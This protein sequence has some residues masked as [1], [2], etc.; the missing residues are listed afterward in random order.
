MGLKLDI[1]LAL[2]I[3]EYR[4]RLGGASCE[5]VP[6]NAVLLRPPPNRKKTSGAIAWI[7]TAP[8]RDVQC[9]GVQPPSLSGH[10][11]VADHN[12][13]QVRFLGSIEWVDMKS[14]TRQHN[15]EEAR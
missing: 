9:A 10:D 8:I 15:V 5:D 13:W 7:R 2:E 4:L 11:D 14:R 3:E 6:W 1:R 12:T